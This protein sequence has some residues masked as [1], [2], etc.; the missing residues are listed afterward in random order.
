MEVALL[1]DPDEGAEARRQR[2][3]GHHHGF[4]R[5]REGAEEQEQDH[6]RGEQGRP[7]RPWH[8][9]VLGDQ[10]VFRDRSD[11]ADLD[12][13][14]GITTIDRTNLRD[15]RGP[16]RDGRHKRADRIEPDD[17]VTDI[18]GS[19]CRYRP[20]ELGRERT[21]RR[22]IELR[23]LLGIQL[24]PGCWILQ[25]ERPLDTIDPID[26]VEACGV[27]HHRLDRLDIR[28][29]GPWIHEDG[30]RRCL[31]RS[32]VGQQRDPRIATRKTGRVDARVRHALLE[33]EERRAG[34]EQDRHDGHEYGDRATH[35]GMGHP[36]PA[37]FACRCGCAAADSE[38][39]KHAP[40]RE[41]ID[42]RPEHA[43]ERRQEGHR[44]DDRGEDDDRPTEPDRTERARLEPEET[45]Q[46][47]GHGDAGED[48]R[49]AGGRDGD[50]DRRLGSSAFPKFLPKAARYE[51]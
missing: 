5:D 48:D 34:D 2:E 12:R 40:R 7:H 24:G 32:E 6:R 44:E 33:A 1:E 17:T 35:H 50:L 22:R 4:D 21:R 19:E 23:H 47:D 20:F 49:L 41:R 43:E 8:A 3:E 51:Q 46:A 27:V 39:T 14:D 30:D 26:G 38:P 37:R 45:G 25:R 13:R 42:S 16:G 28:R 36:L 18:R 10:E 31:A 11:A 29:A 15:D 9:R